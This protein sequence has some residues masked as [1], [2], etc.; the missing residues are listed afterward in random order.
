MK[1]RGIPVTLLLLALACVI[2]ASAQEADSTAPVVVDGDTLFMVRGVSAF[3]AERRAIE[4]A[5][6]IRDFAA[7]R[8][9]PVDSLKVEDA[10]LGTKV[11]AAGRTL[12][13]VVDAD[14]G[15]EGVSR[16]VLA[17]VYRQ[18]TMQAVAR[19]RADRDPGMLWS[20]VASAVGATLLLVLGLILLSR[21]WRRLHAALPNSTL[22]ELQGG[23]NDFP[24][25]LG[26]YWRAIDTFVSGLAG[27]KAG[28]PPVP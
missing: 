2:P 9:L 17:E 25:D 12:F 10:A 22:V 28:Q 16:Q 1:R 27:A 24:R 23:H 13:A 8:S 3:P 18:R 6:R 15:L 14:A 5:G 26:A 19:Y 21:L 20:A 7:D 4:I 11:V